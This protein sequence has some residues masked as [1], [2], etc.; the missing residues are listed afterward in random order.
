MRRFEAGILG[1]NPNRAC[2]F[3]AVYT[4]SEVL[5]IVLPVSECERPCV[6]SLQ[7]NGDDDLGD[8]H[9]GTQPYRLCTEDPTVHT[10]PHYKQ[11]MNDSCNW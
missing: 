10:I 1:H 4:L 11:K 6:T 5:Y 8:P 7:L 9:P 2:P 3:V